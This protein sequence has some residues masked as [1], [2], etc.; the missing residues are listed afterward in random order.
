MRLDVI[1]LSLNKH[2]NWLPGS[3]KTGLLLAMAA[4]LS[5]C[6]TRALDRAP[7]S[8]DQPWQAPVHSSAQSAPWANAATE[9]GFGVPVVA[10][11][12]Q[13]A[14][15]SAPL[16]DSPLALH[17]LIDHAQRANPETRSAWN[18]ARQAALAVG[19]VEASFLPMLSAN[20]ISGYQQTT[21]PLPRTIGRYD[22]LETEL[23]GTVPALA[24]GW[25]LF[26]FGQRQ[27]VLEGASQLSFAANVLFNAA[28]QKVIRDVTDQFYTYN[29]ARARAQHAQQAFANQK[30][31][32]HAVQA[33]MKAGIATSIELALARQKVAQAKLHQVESEGLERNAYL[34]LLNASGLPP[35]ATVTIAGVKAHTLPAPADRITQNVIQQALT[36]RPDLVAAYAATK[37][38]QADVR[39][40]EA[41]FL[42]KVYL[43][44]VAANN[45]SN[46]DVAGLPGISQSATTGGVLLGVSLPLFDG[47]LRRASLRGAEIRAEQ[48]QQNLESRKKDAIREIVAAETVLH[49]TLQSHQAA[50]ELVSTARLT[51]DAALDAYR[52][53][54]GTLPVATQA[55]TD[56][57]MASQAR[58]DA[59]NAALKA[60]ANLAFVM[61]NMTAARDSWIPINEM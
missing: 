44:A 53:G 58:S 26:D 6:A 11:L 48:A 35:T 15:E 8:P 30:A 42:P 29:S 23:S 4:S 22:T 3:W 46:F 2:S 32:E 40:K 7:A 39:A 20:V 50:T 10:E 45:R 27:A 5:A 59:Y 37:A 47:G 36:R 38:A 19:M 61:G 56:L 52:N 14:T 25:L 33:R 28:H 60:A 43:G 31:I 16:N 41:E 21:R 12:A 49:A 34:A 17:D 54:V 57:L 55:A 51:Y 24:L 18:H 13:L 1:F 9:P